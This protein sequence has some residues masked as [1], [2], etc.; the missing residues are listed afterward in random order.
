MVSIVYFFSGFVLALYPASA[1]LANKGI[2]PMNDTPAFSPFATQPPPNALGTGAL[3]EQEAPKTRKS[4]KPKT[5]KSA[6]A[7]RKPKHDIA[8]QVKALG[9]D[10]LLPPDKVPTRKRAV[11]QPRAP[12]FTLFEALQV[13]RGLADEDCGLFSDLVHRIETAP[14]SARAR[15]VA[16][17]AKVFA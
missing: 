8:K 17:L 3:F 14:K 6:K 5:A 16:A 7:T 1:G 4:R 2:N 10:S 13:T 11:K 15:I 12:K 9:A